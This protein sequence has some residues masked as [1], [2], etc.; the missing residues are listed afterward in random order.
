MFADK[1]S[2]KQAYLM[3]LLEGEGLTLNE[4]TLW[5][6]FSALVILLKEKIS[7]YRAVNRNSQSLVKQVYYFSM[8]FLIGRLLLNY[9]I[10]FKIE[11]LV[12][13]GL[14]DLSIDLDDLLEQEADPGLGNGGLGRLAACFLD[15]MAFLGI[16][17]HGNGIRYKYGLFEQKI[18]SGN[19]VEVADNWLTNGYPWET[20]K[21]EEAIVVKL[22]GNVRTDII[23]GRLTFF[24]ENYESVLAVPYDVPIMSYDNTLSINTL[25]LWSA[26]PICGELDLACFNRGEFNLTSSYESEV[27][28]ISYILYPD[29]S[30]RAG[31]ELR[32]KQ[33]YFF[34]AAGLGSIVRDY[35]K[36]IIQV[37]YKVSHAGWQ[38]TSMIPIRFCVSLS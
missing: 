1:E 22:K 5:D 18:V 38:F 33:E 25:R 19:Q 36:G 23:D 12:R 29:E 9:L 21:P 17:G 7:M 10:N 4:A 26:K 37:P 35:K 30:S 2:F 27:E 14:A 3:K 20:C 32:L 13:E 15:S 31:R 16:G 28:T 24:H 8:E 6:K 34:V 11:D